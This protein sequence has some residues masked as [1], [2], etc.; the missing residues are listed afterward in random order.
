MPAEGVVMVED[1]DSGRS[2]TAWFKMVGEDLVVA[3]GGGEHPHVGC[4][5]LTTPNPGRGSASCSV[6]KLL[7]ERIGYSWECIAG[8]AWSVCRFG[9]V[10][11]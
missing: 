5:V 8:P 9:I 2:V 7:P 3:V 10:R 6:L 11:G 1:P 4:V